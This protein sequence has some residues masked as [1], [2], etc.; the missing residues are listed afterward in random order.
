MKGIIKRY[1]DKELDNLFLKGKMIMFTDSIAAK[2]SKML[3][4]MFKRHEVVSIIKNLNVLAMKNSN[5]EKNYTPVKSYLE[6]ILNILLYKEKYSWFYEFLMP[7]SILALI[8]L[9]L[10]NPSI[11]LASS[12][13]M[14]ILLVYNSRRE[15]VKLVEKR[16]KLDAFFETIG[17]NLHYFRK[18]TQ[19][20]I[21]YYTKNSS[22][23]L[24]PLLLHFIKYHNTTYVSNSRYKG[25]YKVIVKKTSSK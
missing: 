7:I 6:E 21:N 9:S 18:L 24:G 4:L 13:T 23:K 2:D 14:I 3:I 20:L 19:E 15:A 25:L 1:S 16:S 11:V 22:K 17:K 12:L 5:I 8:V 10:Y